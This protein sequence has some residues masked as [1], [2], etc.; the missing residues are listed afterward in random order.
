[1]TESVH[2]RSMY[3][4]QLI[5]AR[6]RNNHSMPWFHTENRKKHEGFNGMWRSRANGPEA[7]QKEAF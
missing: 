1:M 6:H 5:F 3:F 4:R 2:Q 7:P